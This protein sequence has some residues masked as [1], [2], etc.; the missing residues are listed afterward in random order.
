MKKNEELQGLLS[1]EYQSALLFALSGE[2][3]Y[4]PPDRVAAYIA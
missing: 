4:H 1:N 2:N 3:T